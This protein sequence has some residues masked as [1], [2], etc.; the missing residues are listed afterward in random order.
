MKTIQVQDA[1][2]T[3]RCHDKTRS[4][5]GEGKGPAFRRGYIGTE[6]DMPTLLN[7]GKEHLYVF[8]PEEGCVHEETIHETEQVLAQHPLLKSCKVGIVTT[9]NEVYKGRIKDKFGPVARKEFEGYGCSI[10]VTGSMSVDPDDQ[11]PASIRATGAEVITYGV[12]T[13]PETIHV[14]QAQRRS[15]SGAA[16]LRNV[17]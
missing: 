11:T 3:V 4:V 12:P 17:L 7:I 6:E 8:D 1:V 13:F 16:R 9:E 14:H 2:N 10:V 5:P 15:H